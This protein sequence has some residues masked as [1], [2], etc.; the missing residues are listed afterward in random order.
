MKW[1]QS[2]EKALAAAKRHRSSGA[3]PSPEATERS[4]IEL[5]SRMAD[6]ARRVQ[7]KRPA[8]DYATF[9]RRLGLS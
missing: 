3:R 6:A 2:Y 5:D 9:S 4:E 8:T 1:T 7:G